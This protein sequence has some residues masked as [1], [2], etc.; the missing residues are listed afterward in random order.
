MR[1]RSG[2]RTVPK[3]FKLSGKGRAKRRKELEAKIRAEELKECTFNPKTTEA[4]NR[5]L[6]SELLAD[7]DSEIEFEI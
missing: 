6:I 5:K 2:N 7:E 3:P 1:Y 4:R